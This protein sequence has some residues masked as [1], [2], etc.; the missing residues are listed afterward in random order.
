MYLRTV[1][2]LSKLISLLI[3]PHNSVRRWQR[4]SALSVLEG[5]IDRP[6][7]KYSDLFPKRSDWLPSFAFTSEHIRVLL[8]SDTAFY[9]PHMAFHFI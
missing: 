6:G 3:G 2:C 9:T 7:K 5:C 8:L 1:S 4:M